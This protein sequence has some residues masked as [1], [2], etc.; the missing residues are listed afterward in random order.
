MGRLNNLCFAG[1]G[2]P[3][4]D[5]VELA[6][7]SRPVV[8]VK[9]GKRC[10]VDS[11][12]AAPAFLFGPLQK[13][14]ENRLDIFEPFTQ[15]WNAQLV[16]IQPIVEI[17]AET[18]GLDVGEQIFIRGGE[19]ADVDLVAACV[20]QG[21]DSMVFQHTQELGLSRRTHF[22]DLVEKKRAPLGQFEIGQASSA[23]H[24]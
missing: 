19:D 23:W 18:T 7:V 5:I 16:D 11:P 14:Q 6:Y 21:I 12:N 10:R 2:Q 3:F 24:R 22:P 8:V 20:S 15:R 13:N 9:D 17:E 4:D 1:D